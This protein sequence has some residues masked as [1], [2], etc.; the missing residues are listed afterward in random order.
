MRS[1]RSW[2]SLHPQ[3]RQDCPESLVAQMQPM[4]HLERPFVG[5]AA[6]FRQLGGPIGV[7]D[8]IASYLTHAG[9]SP[10]LKPKIRMFERSRHNAR[11]HVG[12]TF[13]PALR[14]R[15]PAITDAGHVLTDQPSRDRP[16]AGGGI[17]LDPSL[18]PSSQLS[19]RHRYTGA[20]R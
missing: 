14:H 8:N 16:H 1:I 19:R 15:E 3:S 5:N 9:I 2:L 4:L 11:G 18:S 17:Q 7:D 20:R 6:T 10:A 12:R 13:D